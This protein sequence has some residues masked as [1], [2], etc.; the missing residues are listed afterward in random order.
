MLFF[1]IMA[2]PLDIVQRI[3]QNINAF[4]YS[5]VKIVG[6]TEVVTPA[7]RV[8]DKINHTSFWSALAG[9]VVG[10][11][12]TAGIFALAAAG[13]AAVGITGGLA[14]PIVAAAVGA[15]AT[16][17]LS[18]GISQISGAV[19]KFVDEAIGGEPSGP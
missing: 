18:G 4:Q 15:L 3:T 6:P 10:A 11:V 8:D 2:E 14:G 16:F 9:A 19:T 7:A 1:L 13:V 5:Q 17:A 12:V